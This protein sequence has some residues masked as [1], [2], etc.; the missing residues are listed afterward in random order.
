MTCL[1]G[2]C[3]F[4][5]L[6]FVTSGIT[7]DWPHYLRESAEGEITKQIYQIIT[8]KAVWGSLR[9]YQWKQQEKQR[10]RES[11]IPTFTGYTRSNASLLRLDGNR[12]RSFRHL[13]TFFLL[14]WK[15]WCVS[16][17]SHA[18]NVYCKQAVPSV[19]EKQSVWCCIYKRKQIWTRIRRW[20]CLLGG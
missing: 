13:S 20:P 10:G 5:W 7:C 4:Y 8:G 3:E 2:N 1:L 9:T 11:P 16:Y 14:Y 19:T 18:A 17:T 6:L 15:S 12:S